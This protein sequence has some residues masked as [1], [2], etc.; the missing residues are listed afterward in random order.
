MSRFVVAD[1]KKCIGCKTCEIACVDAHSE[2]NMF[3]GANQDIKFNPCLTVIKTANF[4]A[5][6]QCRQC[7]NAPCANACPNGSIYEKDDA[8]FINK[9]TCIGCKTCMLA[10]PFGALELITHF[11]AGQKVLQPGLKCSDVNGQLNNKA[12][13]V[14]N[15]CDL[16]EDRTNGSGPACVQ[17]CPTGALRLVKTENIDE[18]IEKKRR[19]SAMSLAQM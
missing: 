17:M 7:E 19:Q 3:T 10:C 2:H 11:S 14:A 12:K 8:I 1:P 9:E 13:L 6:T 16:C 15:K 5:P 4:S 18:A